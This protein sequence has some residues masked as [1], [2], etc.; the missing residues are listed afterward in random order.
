MAAGQTPRAAGLELEP[1]NI[2][3]EWAREN[4]IRQKLDETQIEYAEFKLSQ[5][6][7]GK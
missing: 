6:M 7:E 1:V 3:V 4:H 2:V 5:I